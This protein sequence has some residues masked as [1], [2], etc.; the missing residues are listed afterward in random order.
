[1]QN[2]TILVESKLWGGKDKPLKVEVVNNGKFFRVPVYGGEKVRSI[3]LNRKALDKVAQGGLLERGGRTYAQAQGVLFEVE[4]TDAKIKR[5]RTQEGR[6]INLEQNLYENLGLPKEIPQRE[7]NRILAQAV[8]YLVHTIKVGSLG[9]YVR[10]NQE[11]RLYLHGDAVQATLQKVINK[12]V[13]SLSY[14]SRTAENSGEVTREYRVEAAKVNALTHNAFADQLAR[15]GAEV[16]ELLLWE[17]A[18]AANTDYDTKIEGA[19][20]KQKQKFFGITIRELE[21]ELSRA[22]LITANAGTDS[23]EIFER[24]MHTDL[25]TLINDGIITSVEEFR[26]LEKAIRKMG[27]A[28]WKREQSERGLLSKIFKDTPK[29]PQL[30]NML[31]RRGMF[32]LMQDVKNNQSNLVTEVRRK[33]E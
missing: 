26:Q 2:M 7:R 25:L 5:F 19:T 33:L 3:K 16:R 6:D 15:S 27:E 1:M 18:R 4:K 17:I 13:D 20:M 12:S 30:D 14:T 11:G 21:H 9:K 29:G 8:D 10:A 24:K 31:F 32:A 23:F 28:S 22:E